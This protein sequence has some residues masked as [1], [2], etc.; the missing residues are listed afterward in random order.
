MTYAA[1]AKLKKN[2]V[3]TTLSSGIND[4][5]ATIPV[6]ELSV[7]YDADAALITK[8]IVIGYDDATETLT[9]EIT[10]TGASAASGAGNLTGATRGVK[11]DGTIGEAVAWSGGTKI[12]VMISTGIYDQI[13]D[14]IAAH[15]S[16]KAP[17]ASPTFTGTVEMPALKLTTGA[18]VGK[19]PVSDAGGDLAYVAA[20][21]TIFLSGAGGF[22]ATTLPD[23]GFLKVELATNKVDVKGTKFA[24]SAAALS[25]H[26]WE[27]TMPENYN[28]GT[29]TAQFR[30]MTNDAGATD[31]VRWVIQALSRSN[32]EALDAAYGTAVGVTDTIT[33]VGDLMVSAVSGAITPSGT[34]AGGCEMI[35][36]VGR[37]FEN[38]DTSA[39]YGVLLGV[40]I[41]YTT[42][43]Y[44]DE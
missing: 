30:W 42:D 18:G 32:D 22:P 27:L 2:S 40:I 6:S 25:Y 13:C 34:P 38:G 33:A 12:A 3:S 37:D 20:K 17:I 35:I 8:G 23:A 26:V 36:R 14:N 7:F 15:E 4:T 21:R 28:G 11:K 39:N 5:D 10:I 16:A 19:V 29:F 44:S 9:E 31:D 41:S 1:L 43:N 24:H